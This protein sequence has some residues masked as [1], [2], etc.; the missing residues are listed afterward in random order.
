MGK[1]ETIP[2]KKLYLIPSRNGLTRPRSVRGNGFPFI[3]MGELFAYN[4]I[5]D[6]ETD[7]V[8]LTLQEREKVTLKN[9]DLLFARQ[10]LVFEGAG[11]CTIVINIKKTTAFESH[12]IR[13]RL[14]PLLANPNFYYY[15]FNSPLNPIGKIVQQ[16]AQAG[17]RG[18]DLDNLKVTFPPLPTQE[19]IASIL[20]AYDDAI[21]NNNKR[22]K[23]LE[24]MAENLYR[25]WFVRMRFPGHKT[26]EYENGLPKGWKRGRL[27]DAIEVDPIVKI[28]KGEKIKSVPMAALSTSQMCIDENEISC[29]TTATGSRF[30]NG[31]VLLAKITPCL[32][33]GKTGFVNFLKENEYGCGS[34]EFIVLRARTLSPYFVYFLARSQYFRGIAIGSM[35][36]ADGRQR[37]SASKI[38]QIKLICPTQDLV[39]KFSEVSKPFFDAIFKLSA[40]NHKLVKQRNRLLPHLLSGNLEIK[41]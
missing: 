17:I 25:E 12:I 14:N 13:V 3:N 21:E 39:N 29:S 15:Y 22:I 40:M 27:E 6:I 23:I 9:G 24:K 32:E 10:S 36:G 1:W 8:E 19:K 5:S 26:A 18:S 7:L 37:A 16:C 34:T 2:F 28:P 31:D 20:S 35:N 11:K 30:S 38:K 41:I 4:R 33:N